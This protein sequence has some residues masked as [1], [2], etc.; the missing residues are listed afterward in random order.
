MGT[1]APAPP[2]SLKR[3]RW[4]TAGLLLGMSLGALEATVV[5]TAMPTVIA[6]L[7]GLAHYSWVFSAYLLTSTASVPIWGRLSDLYGRRR[8]YLTG[9]AIF[10]AGSML[11]GAATSMEMLIVAR[12][13]QGLGTGAIIPLS[14][15]IVG[16]LYSLKERA[17]SQALF[18]G[19]WGV[20]SVA[21]P[22]VGG[23]IT[24]ALSWRWVFY[25]N[26]PF[27]L[28]A[29]AII[30]SAYPRMQRLEHVRIDWVGAALL[31]AGISSLL[32]ALGSDIGAAAWWFAGGA[33]VLLT[34]FVLAERNAA[35]PILPMELLKTPLIART[36][37][38]V[39]LVGMALF[40]AITF[41]PLFVQGV[42]GATAT[43]AGQVLT[44]LFLGWVFM[45]VAS[46]RLTVKLGY[47]KL[48]I[49]GSLL[50][51]LGFLGMTTIG[52]DS[53]RSGV[54]GFGLLIGA[55]MGMSM[56]SLLLAVQHG[57]QRSH[58]GLATSLQQFSRS[59]GGAV[60]VAG[61]GALV[62]RGLSGLAIP[63]GAEAIAAGGTLL[64]GP[65]R[66]QFASA[67]H[68]V[69]VAGAVLAGAALLATFFL[70]PVDFG[71][72]VPAAAGEQML[73]AE[74]TNLEPEDEPVAI[75]D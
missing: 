47:R 67:L 16:E 62:T 38:V 54:L 23:Y 46:A 18:S 24:D 42:M 55:G 39:F 37:L 15:T 13:I 74:M 72:G 8:M 63:G 57:V 73:A 9:V 17:R 66:L 6:T 71:R 32:I 52:A 75:R 22:L 61:M 35:D 41:I 44:P 60:G 29:A 26:L 12:A 51:T 2:I 56:L 5:S 53:A 3:R 36:L 11:S 21:G 70:P 7:G 43:Q 45:S 14:M 59:V 68:Q 30:M 40:G 65:V 4:I 27:G 64:A 69:F 10:L 28:V 31:F 50:I 34:A 48:A 49:T 58:L 19:V 1:T 25:I 20:A 33:A